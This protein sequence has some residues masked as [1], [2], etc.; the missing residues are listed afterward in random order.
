MKIMS[1]VLMALAFLCFATLAVAQE[2]KAE[3]KIALPEAVAKVVSEAFPNVKI[4]G[5]DMEKEM[6]IN[7]YNIELKAVRVEME[8]AEDGTV[9]EVTTF[10]EMADVP[11]TAA[12][13]IQKA[14]R[15]ATI[16][17]IEKAENRAEIKKE[18][19][20]GRIVKLDSP[21][22]VYEVA[23]AKGKTTGEIKVAPDGRIVK[24]LKWNARGAKKD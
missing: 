10:V 18:G 2:K 23:L 19:K 9:M 20:I 8:V 7:I 15:G 21:S 14:A 22:L 17:E 1:A 12:A 16:K 5:T 13:V 11:G 6:G 4:D 3:A 24:A